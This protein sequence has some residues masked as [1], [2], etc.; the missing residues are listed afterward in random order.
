MPSIIIKDSEWWH[1]KILI[2][3]FHAACRTVL[4]SAKDRYALAYADAGLDLEGEEEIACQCL[5]LLNNLGTWRGD[6]ARV[7]K[8]V[9][10]RL[11]KG[12]NKS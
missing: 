4:R 2:E 1:N 8:E 12:W 9:F 10:R 11:A 7:T 3:E 5:Y 6:E